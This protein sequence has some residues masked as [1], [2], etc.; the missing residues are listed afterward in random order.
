LVDLCRD[1]LLRVAGPEPGLHHRGRIHV[2]LDGR[3]PPGKHITF[4]MRRNVH[5]ERVSSGIHQR[6]NVALGDRLR[7]LKIRW[8][9]GCSDPA[10]QYGMIFVHDSN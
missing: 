2:Q 4:E 1:D 6:D 8:Q 5:H 10:R 3:F 9:K 7:L